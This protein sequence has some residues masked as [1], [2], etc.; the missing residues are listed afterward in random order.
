MVHRFSFARRCLVITLLGP[1]IRNLAVNRVRSIT[2]QV[3]RKGCR[4]ISVKVPKIIV[5][6][7]ANMSIGYARSSSHAL[8][9]PRGSATDE[10]ELFSQAG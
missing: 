3:G 1:Q 4:S 5:A 6:R 2:A 10:V 9:T 8:Q 7:N